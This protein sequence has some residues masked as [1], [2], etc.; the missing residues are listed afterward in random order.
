MK[1]GRK[2]PARDALVAL[3]AVALLAAAWFGWAWWSAA[4]DD[5]LSLARERDRVLS[6]I[7]TALVVLNTIDHRSADQDVDRWIAVTAGQL[8][9][10]L[11]GERQLQL[12]RAEGTRTVAEATLSKAAVTE[13]DEVAGTARLVA[14]L[15]VQVAT[16]DEP[17]D[18]RRSRLTVE[19]QRTDGGWK[20]SAV[21]AAS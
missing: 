21:Q 7:S 13:L 12:D 10:D 20:V 17:A 14:V 5:E 2:D 16:E 19:A 3:A 9:K 18:S 11:S 6:E 4:Q 1:T 8:H 15:D